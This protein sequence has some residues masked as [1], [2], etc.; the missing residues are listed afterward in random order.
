MSAL[1]VDPWVAGI[2]V[3]FLIM[4]IVNV[5]FIYVAVAGADPVSPSYAAEAR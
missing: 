4:L 3:G 5:G 1:R 2:V